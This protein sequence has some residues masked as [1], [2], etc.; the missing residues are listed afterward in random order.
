MCGGLEGD[1][2]GNSY[3]GECGGG[4]YTGGKVKR[5]RLQES[6]CLKRRRA[7]FTKE[8]AD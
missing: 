8:V 6:H 2:S 1:T 5:E 4:N 7:G 3:D